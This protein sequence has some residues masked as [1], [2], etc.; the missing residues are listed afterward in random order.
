MKKSL[1]I[2]HLRQTEG[3]NSQTD[4]I[5]EIKGADSKDLDRLN[6]P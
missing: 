2:R 3:S 6:G 5:K 1:T 4:R